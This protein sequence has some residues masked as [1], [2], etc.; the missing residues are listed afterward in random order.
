MTN[1]HL[2]EIFDWNTD[3]HPT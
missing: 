2:E 3:P 1:L